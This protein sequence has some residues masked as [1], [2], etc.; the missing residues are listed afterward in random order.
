MNEINTYS[1]K[2]FEDIKHVNE[3]GQEYWLAREL[4]VI[5]EY[6]QWRNFLPVIEKAK[7]SCNNS[8]FPLNDHFADVR[9]MVNI[10]SDTYREINDIMLSRYACYLIVMNGDPRK[11][12][13]ALGGTMPEDLPTPD[14]SIKQLEKEQKKLNS[15][16]A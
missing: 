5:L 13:I 15:S 9:K 3:Y 7:E 1:D 12:I 14:K 11:E 16:K 6:T 10:G 8:D 2:I 4:R